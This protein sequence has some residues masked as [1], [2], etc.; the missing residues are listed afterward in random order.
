LPPPG[1]A[2]LWLR[3]HQLRQS[4]DSAHEQGC[5]DQ[6]RGEEEACL[7]HA[8]TARLFRAQSSPRRHS[9][10][11]AALDEMPHAKANCAAVSDR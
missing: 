2:P 7:G 5:Q 9:H 1:D 10:R 8:A 11:L 3:A 6:E 4:Q